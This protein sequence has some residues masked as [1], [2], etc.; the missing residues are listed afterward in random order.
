MRKIELGA[1]QLLSLQKEVK[2]KKSKEAVG[3]W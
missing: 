1:T 2:T 3:W